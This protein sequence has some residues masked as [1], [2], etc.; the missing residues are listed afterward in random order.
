M[1]VGLTVK[2]SLRRRG[3]I[4]ITGIPQDIIDE[5]IG[6]EYINLSKNSQRKDL[7]TPPPPQ[8]G[9]HPSRTL[10]KNKK[11][12]IIKFVNGKFAASTLSNRLIVKDKDIYSDSILIFI[13]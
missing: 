11:S 2:K 8:E 3:I 9:G 12:V 5:N 1:F 7:H 10:E 4:E 13:Y 6:D